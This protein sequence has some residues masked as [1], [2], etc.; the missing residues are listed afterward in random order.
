MTFDVYRDGVKINDAPI[1][2]K[3]NITDA[4]GTAASKYTIK[5]LLNDQISETSSEIT[6]WETPYR[7]VHL[8]RPRWEIACW[9]NSRTTRLHIHTR[10]RI[11]R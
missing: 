6:V 3:T 11:G 5:S 1:K 4:E 8:N 9:R 10:R 7:K 2:N